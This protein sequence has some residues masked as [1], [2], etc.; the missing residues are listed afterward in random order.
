MA[1]KLGWLS[2]LKRGPGDSRDYLTVGTQVGPVL[3]GSSSLV[4][5]AA[6][7]FEVLGIGHD[8][9]VMLKVE[10]ENRARPG[11]VFGL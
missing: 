9:K 1:L 3:D 5:L 8:D 6:T 11:G 2:I 4:F 10:E 7:G